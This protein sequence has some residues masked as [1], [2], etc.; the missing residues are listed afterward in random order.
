MCLKRADV[1]IITNQTRVLVSAFA[2]KAFVDLPPSE[3][4]CVMSNFSFLL[5]IAETVTILCDGKDLSDGKVQAARKTIS[6]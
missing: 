5:F 4:E 6:S 1:I 2:A 3:D